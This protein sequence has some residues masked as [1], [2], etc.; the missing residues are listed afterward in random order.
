M[1]GGLLFQEPTGSFPSTVLHKI[2]SIYARHYTIAKRYIS[3]PVVYHP[4]RPFLAFF[5][6]VLM[7]PGWDLLSTSATGSHGPGFATPSGLIFWMATGGSADIHL[8]HITGLLIFLCGAGIAVTGIVTSSRET[9]PG[10][11][12]H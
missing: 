10:E 3:N 4:M 1:R 12:V 2:Y 11:P 8:V 6:F 9:G 5:G 7:I